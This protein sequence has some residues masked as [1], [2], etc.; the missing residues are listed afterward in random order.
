QVVALTVREHLHRTA[1][2][3]ADAGRCASLKY[4]ELLDICD[5]NANDWR[6]EMRV[7]TNVEPLAL[8]VPTVP[9]M[10]GVLSDFYVGARVGKDLTGV[11]MLGCARCADLA[12]AEL[13]ANGLFALLPLEEL[14]PFEALPEQ[15]HKTRAFDASQ[16]HAFKVWQARAD[17]IMRAV[18]EVLA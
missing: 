5:F 12:K 7:I 1:G 13:S 2:L 11:E 17:R 6:I 15:L 8:Y 3:Q 18:S 16:E 10:V 9:L 14:Q 4:V